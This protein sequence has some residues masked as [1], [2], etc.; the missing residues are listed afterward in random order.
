MSGN[1]RSEPGL[2]RELK[3][4]RRRVAECEKDKFECRKAKE[5]LNTYREE[6]VRAECL[7][8]LGTLSATVAH[9]LTQPLTV[10]SM[11][12]E[13]LLTELETMP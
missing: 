8:S 5:M 13:N 1:K 3:A 4:L 2:L 9:E 7:T 6:M 12:F 10:I 11:S